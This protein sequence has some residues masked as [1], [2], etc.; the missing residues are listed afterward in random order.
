MSKRCSRYTYFVICKFELRKTHPSHHAMMIK[1]GDIKH[2][3][4]EVSRDYL[5]KN[6]TKHKLV[7]GEG[8][9]PSHH[10]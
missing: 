7:L 6:I 1:I 10:C 3:R 5:T 2:L 4:L 9:E 8:L